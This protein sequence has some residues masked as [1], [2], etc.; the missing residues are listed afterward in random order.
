MEG[1]KIPHFHCFSLLFL[2]AAWGQGTDGRDV[3][4]SIVFVRAELSPERSVIMPPLSS[5]PLSSYSCLLP[6]E[7]KESESAPGA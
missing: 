7:K 5:S 6:G 2:S 1:Q 4:M 3:D